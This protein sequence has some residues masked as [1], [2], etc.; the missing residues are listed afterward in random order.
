MLFPVFLPNWNNL[1]LYPL[2]SLAYGCVKTN[3]NKESC[4]GGKGTDTSSRV[5]RQ[6]A[7]AHALPER[8]ACVFEELKEGTWSS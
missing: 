2:Q 3:N 6:K 1:C 8:S 4:V 7:A 5:K